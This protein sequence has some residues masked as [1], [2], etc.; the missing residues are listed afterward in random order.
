MAVHLLSLFM[1]TDTWHLIK[2][3]FNNSRFSYLSLI[4]MFS[5]WTSMRNMSEMQNS[6]FQKGLI[7]H[8]SK[9]IR[10]SEMKLVRYS[11]A[12][13]LKD[14]PSPSQKNFLFASISLHKWWK[15]L[16]ISCSKFFSFPRYLNFGLVILGMLKKRF[17]HKNKVNFEIYGITAWLTKNYSTRIA[18]YLTN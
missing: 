6:Y 14:R 4:W 17:D 12:A 2:N 9:L 10:N 3:L 16:F 11:L 18:Q 7:N 13:E 5:S 15:M 1:N 8:K